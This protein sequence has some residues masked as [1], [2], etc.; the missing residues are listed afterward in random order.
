MHK[1]GILGGSFD[2]IHNGHIAIAASALKECELDK[3]ILIPT[4]N[5]PFKVGRHSADEIDR[6][7]MAFLVADENKGLVCS[8]CEINQGGISYT[9]NT[10]QTL[11]H[12]YDDSML[13]FILGTD[14]FLELESWYNGKE[15]LRTTPFILAIRPG[16]KET[17][18]NEAVERYRKTYNSDITVLNNPLFN[19]SS[20]NIRRCVKENESIAEFVPQCVEEYI[21]EHGLYKE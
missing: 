16:Y 13:Y 21:Y 2:P 7:N 19:I 5:Q 9:Y 17:E 3:V 8:P 6:L 15:L 4:R 12:V 14:S 18:T 1:I 20:T 11:K 10:L